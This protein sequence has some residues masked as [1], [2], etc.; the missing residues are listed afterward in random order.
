MLPKIKLRPKDLLL[1][2]SLFLLSL[3]TGYSVKLADTDSDSNEELDVTD[4]ATLSQATTNG[5]TLSPSPYSDFE[6]VT[7][8]TEVLESAKRFR[9]NLNSREPIESSEEHFRAESNP[10]RTK[11][12]RLQVVDIEAYCFGSNDFLALGPCSSTFL[13]C[14]QFSEQRQFDFEECP[15]GQIFRNTRCV[16]ASDVKGCFNTEVNLLNDG[17]EKLAEAINYCARSPFGSSLYS[18]L[19]S[20]RRQDHVCSRQALVCRNSDSPLA[21]SCPSD[22]VLDIES[23]RCVEAPQRCMFVSDGEFAPIHENLLHAFC[24]NRGFAMSRVDKDEDERELFEHK[25]P[26]RQKEGCK[27]WFVTCDAPAIEFISCDEG[28][29]FDPKRRVCRRAQPEDHCPM[30]GVCKGWEW[31]TI[32]L[33]ECRRDFLYCNGLRPTMFQCQRKDAVFKNGH[34]RLATEKGVDCGLCEKGEKKRADK[35][36]EFYFCQRDEHTGNLRW[37]AYRCLAP[38]VYSPFIKEC[39]LPDE[40]RCPNRIQCQQGDSFSTSCGDFFYCYEGKYLP[41]K[42]PH[43]T[44]WDPKQRRCIA[45]DN[46]NRFSDTG[47]PKHCQRGDAKPSVDC[48][49]FKECDSKGRWILSDC[50]ELNT[51]RLKAPCRFCSK[52]REQ[53][54]TYPVDILLPRNFNPHDNQGVREKQCDDGERIINIQECERYM[55]CVDGEWFNLACPTGYIFEADSQNCV[56]QSATS[57][58]QNRP[59]SDFSS[60]YIPPLYDTKDTAVG[61][62]TSPS[63]QIPIGFKEKYMHAFEF[64]ETNSPRRLPSPYDCSKYKECETTSASFGGYY[65]EKQCPLSAQFDPSTGEC[66]YDYQC[67]A[68]KC[69]EG[70]R[71]PRPGQ[72]GKARRCRNG[73]WEDVRCKNNMAFI[74]GRCSK[75]ISCANSNAEYPHGILKC[76]TGHTK[77][78]FYDCAKYLMCHHGQ[79]VEES[80]F[81]GHKYNPEIGRCDPSYQCKGKHNTDCYE[82]EMRQVGQHH[83]CDQFEACIDGKF[84]PQRCPFGMIFDPNLKR[85]AAGHCHHGGSPG[86]PGGHGGDHS[87]EPDHHGS[88]HQGHGHHGEKCKESAGV[89]GFRADGQTCKFTLQDILISMQVGQIM[90]DISETHDKSSGEPSANQTP[91]TIAANV[92]NGQKRNEKRQVKSFNILI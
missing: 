49:T 10:R 29:I 53:T 11:I 23:L 17:T 26:M 79:F 43:L 90:D 75:T 48:Q 66:K 57:C 71:E 19:Q 42:C 82:G 51:G 68:P 36:E 80:C 88:G 50:R 52:I 87:D 5:T 85:C 84:H 83:T 77:A 61:S 8:V 47:S 4:S 69:I 76:I 89:D 28:K 20:D 15:L 25:G 39:A 74:S 34:C 37:Q 56:I 6:T 31:R 64:C 14:G 13:R 44:R 72:C 33:G 55:E 62:P 45:D 16:P 78:H 9:R 3:N 27:N 67:L 92:D 81:N 38:R 12:P 40:F 54:D 30:V 46:C 22:K 1:A 91:V 63:P 70:I 86:H 73:N 41:N 65:I 21:I 35:C 18:A 24:D 58:R 7:P 2:F 60:V 59:N 32:P